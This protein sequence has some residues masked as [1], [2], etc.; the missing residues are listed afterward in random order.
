LTAT[1]AF[2]TTVTVDGTT[3]VTATGRSV[4]SSSLANVTTGDKSVDY[5]II[6]P[7]AWARNIGAAWVLIAPDA[8]PTAPISVLSAPTS[9]TGTGSGP[10]TVLQATYPAAALGLTGD[11]VLIT[12]TLG[13]TD[14]SFDYTVT[15]SGHKTESMTTLRPGTPDPILAPPG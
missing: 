15:T 5:T 4:G 7:K 14:V 12:I 11:P 6:P 3:A 13:A 2:S 1:S 10:G 8:A 9:V